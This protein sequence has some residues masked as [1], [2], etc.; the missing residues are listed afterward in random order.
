MSKAASN[1][2]QQAYYCQVCEEAQATCVAFYTAPAMEE[3]GV[4]ACDTDSALCPDCLET[5][6][7]A[8]WAE[9]GYCFHFATPFGTEY[10]RITT[11]RLWPYP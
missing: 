1:P 11:T 6:K 10:L 4:A 2:T 9:M 3:L 5:L 7:S 8:E